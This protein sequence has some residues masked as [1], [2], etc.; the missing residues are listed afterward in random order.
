MGVLKALRGG[1]DVH[2]MCLPG[3]YQGWYMTGGV[4]GI[5]GGVCVALNGGWVGICSYEGGEGCEC[6]PCAGMPYSTP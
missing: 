4:E 5:A 2:M 6:C 3:R 1:G